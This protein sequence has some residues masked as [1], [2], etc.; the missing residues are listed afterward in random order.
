MHEPTASENLAKTTQK[1]DVLWNAFE[2]TVSTRRAV[3]LF[4]PEA[5][6]EKVIQQS[7]DAALLAPSASNLQSWD[8]YWVR[9]EDKRQMLRR[10]C[11][12]QPS[13][14]TAPEFIVCVARYG[15]WK[16][17]RDWF[18]K[19]Y[20][21]AGI[22]LPKPFDIYYQKLV[23]LMYVIGPFGLA[24]LLK[25]MLFGVVRL[26]RPFSTTPYNKS[27]LILSAVK[28]T[29]LACQNLMLAIRAQGYD[30]C[31]LDGFDPGRTSRLLKLPSDSKIVMVLAIGKRAPEDVTFGPQ[32]RCD[33][34]E[35]VHEI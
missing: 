21:D 13:S 27:D 10:Y 8:F 31:P 6:P 28:N 29:A 3:R 35:M 15:V 23:P 9:S 34:S 22:T 17:R 26:F 33:R 24:G 5:V 19:F 32:V 30:S 11:M 20:A 14:N 7:L 16:R 12:D 4:T 18:L 25:R 1:V 2:W